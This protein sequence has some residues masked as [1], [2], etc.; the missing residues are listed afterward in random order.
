MRDGVGGEILYF[1]LT[2]EAELHLL[3]MLLP[4]LSE[5]E[6]RLRLYLDKLTNSVLSLDVIFD[7]VLSNADHQMSSG[8]L[9]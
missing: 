9:N 8:L 2:I 5:M 1:I 6:M 4:F 3:F 7:V